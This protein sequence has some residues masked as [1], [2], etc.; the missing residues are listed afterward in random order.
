MEEQ[1]VIMKKMEMSDLSAISMWEWH[2]L[3]RAQNLGDLLNSPSFHNDVTPGDCAEEDLDVSDIAEILADRFSDSAEE[4]AGRLV[5][6][7][8]KLRESGCP[9]TP[10]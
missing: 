1:R 4:R 8:K 10:K 9:E 2:D 7:L 3:L 5:E 6:Y